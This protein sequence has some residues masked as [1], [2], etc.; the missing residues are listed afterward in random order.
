MLTLISVI[1]GRIK[2][3]A[4]VFTL[5]GALAAPSL[6]NAE[7]T[8]RLPL[9]PMHPLFGSWWADT[10]YD[11]SGDVV[12]QGGL[13]DETVFMRV[14][15]S[16]NYSSMMECNFLGGQFQEAGDDGSIS[17][18][19]AG[20]MVTLKGCWGEYPPTIGFS[21]IARFEREGMKLSLFDES[22]QKVAVFF[23]A[24]AMKKAMEE[25]LR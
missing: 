6:S 3:L 2:K 17:I 11:E 25:L 1:L 13:T 23:N 8:L 4:V 24:W 22:D 10:L 20:S 19:P 21:R 18:S 5:L 14:D 9:L 16:G 7:D 12:W 15:L